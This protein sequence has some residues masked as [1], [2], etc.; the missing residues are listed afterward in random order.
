[1]KLNEIAVDNVEIK[2]FPNRTAPLMMVSIKPPFLEVVI[3][4][5]LHVRIN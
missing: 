2:K 5:A 3:A 4:E 1:V